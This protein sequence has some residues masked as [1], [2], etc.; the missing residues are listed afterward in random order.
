MPI[1]L[2]LFA[3]CSVFFWIAFLGDAEP[4]SGDEGES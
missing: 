2:A 1:L 3:G 4:D